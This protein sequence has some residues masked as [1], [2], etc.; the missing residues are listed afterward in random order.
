YEEACKAL[1]VSLKETK[2]G[3]TSLRDPMKVLKDLASEYSKL[4]SNDIRRTNLLSSVGGKD[5]ADALNAILENYDM[6][7]KMLQEYANGAGSMAAE[8]EKTANSWEGSMN[9]LSNTWTD[10]VGNVVNSDAII[11]VINSLNDLL[12]VVNNVTDRL[13]SLGSIGLGGLGVGITAFVKNFA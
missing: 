10:T 12:S 7:E 11:T 3:M 13:S 1:N 4:D 5:R 9:R 2:N 6:Y 8:A